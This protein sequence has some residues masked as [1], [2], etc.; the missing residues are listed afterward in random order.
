M[1]IETCIEVLTEESNHCSKWGQ[2][3]LEALGARG[4]NETSAYFAPSTGVDTCSINHLVEKKLFPQ[5]VS[6]KQFSC[7]LKLEKIC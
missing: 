4:K 5:P 6:H 1:G 3:A 2:L 7:P